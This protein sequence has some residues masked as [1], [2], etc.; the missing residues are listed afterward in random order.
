MVTIVRRPVLVALAF[1]LALATRDTQAACQVTTGDL[2]KNGLQ[3]LQIVGD[4]RKQTLIIDAY[5]AQT[6]VTLD[7][8]ADGKFNHPAAGDLDHKVFPFAPTAYVIL[9][10]SGS[11]AITVNLADTWAG[12]VRT[13]DVL[14][15]GGTDSF[16]LAGPGALTAK[17]K[18][19]LNVDGATGDDSVTL[20]LPGI[21][22]SEL[23]VK[24]N[25]QDGQNAMT[26]LNSRPILHGGIA[27]V[28]A[29]LLGTYSTYKV[30]QTS[31]AVVDGTLDITI[32]GSVNPNAGDGGTA[33]IGGQIGSHG[34]VFVRA[35]LGPGADDFF[36]NISVTSI[37]AGG[38]LHVDVNG[39]P[40]DDSLMLIGG[41]TTSA[42]LVDVNLFGGDGNDGV[43]VDLGGTN[44][45]VIRARADGGPGDDTLTCHVAMVAPM[46]AKPVLDLFVF[47]GGGSDTINFEVDNSGPNGPANYGPAGTAF[48][49]GGAGSD[50]C[51]VLGNGRVHTRNC[52]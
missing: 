5:Q 37:A 4:A 40:G 2:D 22:D 50:H 1:G 48:V 14:L 45:G 46:T 15:G 20:N 13:I 18:L 21:D 34:R 31:A 42:G 6:V 10:K 28:N 17:S 49:D 33:D 35:N 44:T 39:G 29:E 52:E 8:D 36:G 9:L 26:V 16:T 30:K 27:L 32:D 24:A 19:I 3:D 43:A 23:Y 38:E 47:G 41:A 51:T 11:D 7:C 12:Q 25:L